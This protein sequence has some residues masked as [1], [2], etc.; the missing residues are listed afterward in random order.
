MNEEGN[1]FLMKSPKWQNM[2]IIPG[3]HVEGGESIED[4]LVREVKEET[5]LKIFS[6]QFLKPYEFIYS[7]DYKKDKHIVSL[8]YIATTKDP[9]NAVKLNNEATEFI[10]MK[11]EEVLKREDVHFTIKEVVQLFLQSKLNKEKE[12]EYKAGWQRAIADY[13]NLQKEIERK[14]AEWIKMSEQQIIEEFLPVYDNFK[15]AFFHHPEVGDQKQIKNWIDGIGYI[16]KQFGD[17]LKAHK[18]EEIKTVGEKFD[19][20]IHEAAGEEDGGGEHGKIIREV[21]GGYRM[22]ERVL[23]PARVIINK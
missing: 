5:G 23:K 3:G 19:P 21:T 14:Q 10:W 2:Y 12:E 1:V 7:D 15:T 8:D 9:E 6:L 17:V 11:P 22:G 4:A 20:K 18:V 13:K 16:M